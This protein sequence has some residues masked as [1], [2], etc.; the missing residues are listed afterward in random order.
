[1]VMMMMVV[2][3]V[4][5]VIVAIAILDIVGITIVR[6]SAGHRIAK[7]LG[8]TAGRT[9]YAARLGYGDARNRSDCARPEP[10]AVSTQCT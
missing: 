7:M 1:M 9:L 6:R 10:R 5:V 3:L 4:A 8:Q 2:M